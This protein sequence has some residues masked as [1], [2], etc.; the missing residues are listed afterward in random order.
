MIPPL[1]KYM[2][3]ILTS[4][5]VIDDGV[6]MITHECSAILQNKKRLDPNSFVLYC[7]IKSETFERSLCDLGSSINMMPLSVANRLGYFNFKPTRISLVLADNSIRK[8]IRILVDVP[9][10]I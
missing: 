2:K 10:V 8:P 3:S 9:I 1:K 4:K 7:E 6:M 5:I